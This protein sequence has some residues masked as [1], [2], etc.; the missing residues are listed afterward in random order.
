MDNTAIGLLVVSLIV[1]LG[2]VSFYLDCI[3]KKDKAP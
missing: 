2:V 1:V 3:R